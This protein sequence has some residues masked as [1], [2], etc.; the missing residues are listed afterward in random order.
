M[1]R[2]CSHMLFSA[3]VTHDQNEVT[4]QNVKATIIS[5]YLDSVFELLRYFSCLTGRSNYKTQLQP[6]ISSSIEDVLLDPDMTTDD[7]VTH[8]S[9]A[10][11][12]L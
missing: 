2:V 9:T 1:V 4:G 8:D 10:I 7:V 5:N 3:D 11:W 12:I 6:I